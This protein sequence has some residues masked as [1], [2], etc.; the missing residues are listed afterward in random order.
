MIL[1]EEIMLLDSSSERSYLVEGNTNFHIL[2]MLRLEKQWSER[3][4]SMN[5]YSEEQLIDGPEQMLQHNLYLA[6]IILSC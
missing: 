5:I 4:D 2:L 6:L 3:S 1:I